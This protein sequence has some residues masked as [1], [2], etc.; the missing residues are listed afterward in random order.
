M[1][2][3]QTESQT[4]E[5]ENTSVSDESFDLD[6]IE[7]LYRNADHKAANNESIDIEDDDSFY[8]NKDSDS[9]RLA[10]ERTNRW[11]ESSPYI[12]FAVKCLSTVFENEKHL[13]NVRE[14]NCL[15]FFLHELSDSAKY[16][17]MRLYFRKP[18]W[19]KTED[20]M[21][22][23]S[24]CNIQRA[25]QDL[26]KPYNIVPKD[27][28][29]QPSYINECINVDDDISDRLKDT[30]KDIVADST[31]T[32][33]FIFR[34]N[35]DHSPLKKSLGFLTLKA[36]KK[37]CKD[38]KIST[39]ASTKSFKISKSKKPATSKDKERRD[40]GRSELI[41][42]ISRLATQPSVNT[43]FSADFG[44][45]EHNPLF[46]QAMKQIREHLGDQPIH[47]NPAVSCTLHRA[48][49]AYFR[50]RDFEAEY[51][52]SALLAEFS[53]RNYPKYTILRSPDFFPSRKMFL[54]FEQSIDVLYEA[55]RILT[56]RVDQGRDAKAHAL[57]FGIQDTIMPA[58][59]AASFCD[60]LE[61]STSV[62]NSNR[63]L[64]YTPEWINVG[65]AIKI[66]SFIK[67]PEAEWSFYNVYLKQKLYHARRRGVTYD[68][69]AKV[70]M[71]NLA[72]NS[73]F[74]LN[75]ADNDDTTPDLLRHASVIRKVTQDLKDATLPGAIKDLQKTLELRTKTFWYTKALETCVAGLQDS[76]IHE[77]AHIALKRRIARLE[78]LLK[79]P[80]KDRLDFSYSELLPPLV[81]TIGW[82]K[83]PESA[84]AATMKL[85]SRMRQESEDP[86]LQARRVL[87]NNSGP[88]T[89]KNLSISLIPI[90]N[91]RNEA[92]VRPQWQDQE[93]TELSLTVEGAALQYYMRKFEYNGFHSENSILT[94]FFSLLFWDI[95]F[96]DPFGLSDDEIDPDESSL[97]LLSDKRSVSMFQHHCQTMPL[98]LFSASFYENRKES[99]DR[100]L[101]QIKGTVEA[102]CKYD[103]F[104]ASSEKVKTEEDRRGMGFLLGEI[105]RVHR[106]EYPKKTLCVGLA[107]YE[108]PDLLCIAEVS[109]S[110]NP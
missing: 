13:F 44:N 94:T 30:L 28:R 41:N 47:M 54:D 48:F 110:R 63:S 35:T 25:L 39:T 60:T 90:R 95:L 93:N 89:S 80:A 96:T 36:L 83:A 68:S 33:T 62:K 86:V 7:T 55:E 43:F 69:K 6:A 56:L 21:K 8:C 57:Y 50:G 87:D 19:I 14:L 4:T 24:T 85:I 76:S 17:F 26:S 103:G 23:S 72:K 108:L 109:F 22:Y 5:D 2:E 37:I 20:Y 10:T 71:N 73:A 91:N 98:D 61:I 92:F 75:V 46:R 79:T 38:F 101:L 66:A 84:I 49:L 100:R 74:A 97:S 12:K 31:Q 15:N 53:F 106:R 105:N 29:F 9:N 82:P 65:A 45:P 40:L 77:V 16:L 52:R 88:G 58:L 99:I 27:S 78:S 81:R 34:Y 11:L 32:D 1:S 104:N 51:E 59:F 67:D 102:D 18:N 64:Y 3:S 107:W 42:E 70:E